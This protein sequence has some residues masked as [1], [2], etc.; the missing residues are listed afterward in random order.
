MSSMLF[1]LVSS[2]GHPS[3]FNVLTA[4]PVTL[5]LN[6]LSYI[7]GKSYLVLQC[8][9]WVACVPHNT[10]ILIAVFKNKTFDIKSNHPNEHCLTT[11]HPGISFLRKIK[12]AIKLKFLG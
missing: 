12:I 10:G 7:I 2:E 6:N 5:T 3:V 9:V 4:K 11:G 1:E 8:I